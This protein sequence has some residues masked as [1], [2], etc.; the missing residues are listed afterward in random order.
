MVLFLKL[1]LIKFIKMR[2]QNWYLYMFEDYLCYII[3]QIF[4][5]NEELNLFQKILFLLF[6]VKYKL[7]FI[8]IIEMIL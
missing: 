4:K 5:K 8:S 2:V 7:Q 1:S 6:A 3:L